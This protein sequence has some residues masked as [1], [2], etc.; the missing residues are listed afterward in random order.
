MSPDTPPELQPLR[1]ISQRDLRN[2][3]SAVIRDL[4]AG[5][6]MILTVNRRRIGILTLAPMVYVELEPLPAPELT[7][8]QHAA[9]LRRERIATQLREIADSIEE[10][11]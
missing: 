8:E 11:L 6:R 10:G 3:I 4:Q 2:D 9:E 7:P 5:E 1:T